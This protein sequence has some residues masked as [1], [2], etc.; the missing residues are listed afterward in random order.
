MRSATAAGSGLRGA[1][2][3]GR[4]APRLGDPLVHGAQL[5]LEAGA[6]AAGGDEG[7]RPQLLEHAVGEEGLGEV[8]VGDGG[9]D[10]VDA[11]VVPGAEQGDGPAVGVAGHAHA[12]VA[13]LVEADLGA[14]RQPVDEPGDVGDLAL[15]VVQPD[16]PGGP[17]EAARGPGE[18]GVPVAGEVLGLRADV[19]LAAAEAVAE[20]HGGAAA[21]GSR[22]EE[23]GVDAHPVAGG[24]D[25]VGAAHLGRVVRGDGG[26]GAGPGE[27]DDGGRGGEGTP[28]PRP[29]Q[30]GQSKIH[31]STVRGPPVGP[32]S[33][34]DRTGDLPGCTRVWPC[35]AAA[36]HGRHV[37]ERAQWLRGKPRSTPEG[38]SAGSG[39]RVVTTFP[40]V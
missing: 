15:G 30:A 16:L 13:V 32:L 24:H 10:G 6:A 39:Q 18:D 27:H 21:L 31:A 17:A 40:R 34:G 23:G 26:P 7:A 20:Q 28:G 1:P 3:P 5:G 4:R 29:P 9:G 25:A 22:G 38:A 33:T 19:L 11:V 36:V 8:E 37:P 2:A 12:G 35:T 14:C